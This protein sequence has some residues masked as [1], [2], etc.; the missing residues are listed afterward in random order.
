MKKE[1]F[2]RNYNY[3]SKKW[4][5]NGHYLRMTHLGIVEGVVWKYLV[6]ENIELGTLNHEVSINVHS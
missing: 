5:I 6:S 4:C 1:Y 3:V 2:I